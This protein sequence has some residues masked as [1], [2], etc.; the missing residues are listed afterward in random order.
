MKE[1][2]MVEIMMEII[3]FMSYRNGLEKL[4]MQWK[5]D[6]ERTKHIFKLSYRLIEL[7]VRG[8]PST[9]L[10]VSQWM[11]LFLHSAMMVDDPT[12]QNTLSELL[13]N[14]YQAISK[15]INKTSIK[16]LVD[17]MRLQVPHQK[18]LRILSSICIC[19]GKSIISN[20]INTL[21]LYFH[22]IQK[23][24]KFIINNEV[25]INS[26][27][28]K[29]NQQWRTLQQLH[30]ES[31]RIDELQTWNY[32]LSYFNLLGDVCANRN[33]FGK[34]FVEEH[35]GLDVLCSIVEDPLAQQLNVIEPVLKVI[36]G[37]YIDCQHYTPIRRLARVREWESIEKKNDILRTHAEEKLKPEKCDLKRVL[38]F[39][40]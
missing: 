17:I 10:H 8:N 40:E 38:H 7:I 22:S 12:V 9:K 25:L 2:R 28:N 32:F 29:Q 13:D 26:F 5:S 23:E 39:V 27:I 14:N 31:E 36:H 24:F 34:K 37:A 11:E 30:D 3:Y 1:L 18:Y 21:N 4:F 33:K 19:N 6:R 15:F 16:R 20:Q 35:F